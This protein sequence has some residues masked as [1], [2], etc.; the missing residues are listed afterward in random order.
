M[1]DEIKQINPKHWGK[2]SWVFLN[3]LGLTYSPEKKSDYKIFFSKLGNILPCELCSSHYNTFLPKLDQAL[4]SKQ[5]FIDWLLEIRNDINIKTNKPLI[6]L[7]GT[8]G[9]IYFSNSNQTYPNQNNINQT[10]PNQSKIVQKDN[11]F[12]SKIFH[13]LSNLNISS[14][15]SILIMII[16]ILIIYYYKNHKNNKRNKNKKIINN[17]Y[18]FY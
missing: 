7:S 1:I 18:K 12:I 14:N 5:T 4:E 3:S 8:V 13:K 11:Y 2:S 10:N 15:K 6:D 16:F 9:E 17:K